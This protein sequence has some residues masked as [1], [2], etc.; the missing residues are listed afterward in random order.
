MK[1]N[2]GNIDKIIRIIIILVCTY[3]AY[4]FNF[5]DWKS[6]VLSVFSLIVL[7]TVVTSFCPIFYFLNINSDKFDIDS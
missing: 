1:K 7:A 6:Y 5:V 2:I 4:V 3:F